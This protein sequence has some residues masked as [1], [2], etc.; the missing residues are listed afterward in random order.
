ME[1]YPPGTAG[2]LHFHT[3]RNC[4]SIN[5]I[6]TRLSLSTLC[7]RLEKGSQRPNTSPRIYRWSD[8]MVAGGGRD[9]S[10]GCSHRQVAHAPLHKPITQVPV[11]NSN[12][13]QQTNPSKHGSRR[14]RW[15]EEGG[16]VAV[17][18]GQCGGDFSENTFHTCM[19]MPG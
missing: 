6:C 11:T 8:L 13:L 12:D 7:H 19:V 16:T 15:Q 17:K 4:D 3:P 18:R 1:C 10:S 2:S 14:T 9:S 5:K